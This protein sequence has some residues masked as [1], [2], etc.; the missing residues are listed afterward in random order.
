MVIEQKVTLRGTLGERGEKNKTRLVTI[1]VTGLIVNHR[2]PGIKGS[3][4]ASQISYI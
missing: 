3:K 4:R 1:T 2:D